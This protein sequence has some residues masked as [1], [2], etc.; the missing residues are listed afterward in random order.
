MKDTLSD[1]EVY[2]S[3]QRICD[4]GLLQQRGLSKPDEDGART[5]F[6]RCAA[7]P[8]D[9][10]VGNRGIERNTDE[11]RCLCNGLL[12]SVG[13]GQVKKIS[14]EWTEEPAIITL[15]NRLDGIRRLSRQARLRIMCRTW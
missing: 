2:R 8:V 12:A 13:L 15:G 7:A 9:S 6:Q 3:R 4:I 14:G 10:Y 11:R 1:D 5:L